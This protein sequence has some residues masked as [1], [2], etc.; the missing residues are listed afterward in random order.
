MTGRSRVGVC[1]FVS[2]HDNFGAQLQ[3]PARAGNVLKLEN[4]M[5]N[6]LHLWIL[7]VYT[8]WHKLGIYGIVALLILPIY[9]QPHR[10]E[11]TM[12]FMA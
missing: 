11:S 5:S 4:A 6:A 9:I 3:L 2:Y 10:S 8:V 12:D 7:Q 1:I